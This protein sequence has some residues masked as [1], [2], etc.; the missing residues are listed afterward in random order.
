VEAAAG[1]VND[2]RTAAS[3]EARLA[4]WPESFVEAAQKLAKAR[5]VGGRPDKRGADTGATIPASAQRQFEKEEQEIA[6]CEAAQSKVDGE[7]EQLA[8][9]SFIR[10]RDQLRD[11]IPEAGESDATATAKTIL[12]EVRA[13]R[14]LAAAKKAEGLPAPMADEKRVAADLLESLGILEKR[15][16]VIVKGGE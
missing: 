13:L 15:L 5:G 1:A 10:L 7:L 4:P 6:T 8:A 12:S 9:D 11:L 2:R 16:E 3:D 14:S